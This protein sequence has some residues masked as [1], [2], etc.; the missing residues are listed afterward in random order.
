[1]VITSGLLR[2]L[3]GK[4]IED[5][6]EIQYSDHKV[7]AHEYFSIN[8]AGSGSALAGEQAED[9]LFPELFFLTN[10]SWALLRAMA[11]G[12]GY[13]LLL[14]NRYSKGILYVWTMPENFNDL[15]RLPQSA[16]ST[17]KNYIMA[18]FPIRLDAPAKVALFAYDNNTCI[19]ESFLPVA[20]DARVTVAP[21][22]TK[23]RNLASGEVL[24]IPAPSAEGDRRGGRGDPRGGARRASF[25]VHL[26]PHS[27]AP[28]I[29]E[30]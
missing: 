13:P 27:Y 10:D 5:I 21:E 29:A 15:Y 30:P 14:L 4:G 26:L 6:A 18:D 1:V 20:C 23:L 9:V 16:T 22:F 2:A 3:Q 12:R 11:N 19:V 25:S 28:F 24:T 17:L 7:L 8:G